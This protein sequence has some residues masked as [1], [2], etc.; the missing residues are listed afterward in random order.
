MV[1][2]NHNAIRNDRKIN[3]ICEK[4]HREMRG[5]TSAGRRSRGLGKGI[6]YGHVKGGSQRAAWRRN[7]TLLLKKFR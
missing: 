1:D 2:P 6:G 3:F 5:L 7:N 4:K